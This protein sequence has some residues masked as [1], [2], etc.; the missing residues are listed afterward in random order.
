MYSL[1][2]GDAAIVQA[3]APFFDDLWHY[4]NDHIG[5]PLPTEW[6]LDESGIHFPAYD[7][8]MNQYGSFQFV[9]YWSEATD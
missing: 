7:E 4:A 8:T 6:T 9:P 1:E 3:S 5:L 2:F